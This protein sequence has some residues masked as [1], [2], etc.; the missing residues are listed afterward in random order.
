M[1]QDT[2][3]TIFIILNLT[4]FVQYW[5]CMTTYTTMYKLKNKKQTKK[6]KQQQT[7]L[8][9]HTHTQ[10][11]TRGHILCPFLCL[12]VCACVRACIPAGMCVCM[13]GFIQ[14]YINTNPD[15]S[16]KWSLK[17]RHQIQTKQVKKNSSKCPW[18]VVLTNRF[19]V[20]YLFRYH[21]KGLQEQR[22][23]MYISL[24]IWQFSLFTCCR[25][26]Y[27]L[28]LKFCCSELCN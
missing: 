18:F 22:P 7:F 1:E 4:Q 3:S 24:K 20:L 10:T 23:C 5:L 17:E 21:M 9:A 2:G 6:T 27:K 15:E 8:H 12:C 28:F 16:V 14:V 13:F 11:H 25:P 26:Y 19:V